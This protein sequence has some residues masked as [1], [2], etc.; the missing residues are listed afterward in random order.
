MEERL[1]KRFLHVLEIIDV[2]GRVCQVTTLRWL[3]KRDIPFLTGDD[4]PEDF[5]SC[6]L[7]RT[8]IAHQILLCTLA[9]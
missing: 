9:P 3:K 6:A 8:K 1:D 5:L 4:L 2:S 7:A